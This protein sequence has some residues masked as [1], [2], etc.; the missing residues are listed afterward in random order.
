MIKTLKIFGLAFERAA[1][2]ILKKEG[3]LQGY[4]NL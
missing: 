3:I 2:I 4:H 1:K